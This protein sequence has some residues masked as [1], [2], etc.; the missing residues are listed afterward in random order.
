[1]AHFA[2]GQ[3]VTFFF[4]L[5]GFVLSYNYSDFSGRAEVL[6]FYWARIA[7][8]W[9]SHVATG[10]L[11]IALI[12]N[13]SYF[14]LPQDWRL[15]ITLAY[16][17]LV[18]AWIPVSDFITAYNTVSWSISTEFFFY[19]VFPVL[20]VR[21]SG[22]WR[23][24]LLL[25]F[26]LTCL[27]WWLSSKFPIA[28][29]GTEDGRGNLAYINPLARL[30]EFAL[31]IA[32]CHFYRRF[33][34]S[35]RSR[36][37]GLP[38]TVVEVAVVAL[39]VGSL[40]ASRWLAYQPLV[41]ELLGK[42]ASIVFNTTGLGTLVFA[43]VIFVFAVG[44]G[45]ISRWLSSRLMVFLGE[46]SFG[47]YLVHTLFLLYRQQAPGVFA[48]FS[49]ETV[50]LLYWLSGMSLA[51]LVHLLVEK[52][53][54]V[55]LRGLGERRLA[56]GRIKNLRIIVIYPVFVGIMVLLQPST[57]SAY[58]P[59]GESAKGLI[60]RPIGFV[61]GF[62]LDQ[63]ELTPTG[64]K[65][66]WEALKDASLA[67]RVAVHLLDD[68]GTMRGQLDFAIETGYRTAVIGEKW[69]NLVALNGVSLAS[70]GALG[71][72]V[73]DQHGMTLVSKEDQEAADWNGTRLIVPLEE[74]YSNGG[75][76][77]SKRFDAKDVAGEWSAGSGIARIM[78]NPDLTLSMVTEAGLQG[79]GKIDG[80]KIVVPGWGVDGR[81]SLDGQE[82]VWS[83]GFFWRRK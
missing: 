82:I 46:I 71:I 60:G 19:L 30:F 5:S 20:V 2:L 11:Y 62:Q 78:E 49:E 48:S 45:V 64:L 28:P 55:L 70:I 25:T 61:N 9:P 65:F 38:A 32:V 51:V 73:Y 69:G 35:L 83:N 29:N 53:G 6:K 14:T 68:S 58:E 23:I 3:G 1:L 13:I 16:V 4:V 10:F 43:I 81:L 54:Q 36:V 18:H 41:I 24:K 59:L 8:I 42:T 57:R 75:R 21:W 22:T 77:F 17:A 33:G 79:H 67:K 15:P 7:R 47:L 44:G 40:M 12:G 27:M 74:G 34:E 31:G 80:S 76:K 39:V 52:P 26:G 50:Y 66:S 63:I 56:E 37:A 72:A